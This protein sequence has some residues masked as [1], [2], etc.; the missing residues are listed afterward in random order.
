M[1]VSHLNPHYYNT[2]CWKITR[3]LASGIMTTPY[4]KE[5]SNSLFALVSIYLRSYNF[6]PDSRNI[7]HIT[8]LSD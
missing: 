1:I 3:H 7:L 5:T 4:T 6:K 2:Y 8:I